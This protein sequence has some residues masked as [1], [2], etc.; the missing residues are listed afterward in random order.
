MQVIRTSLLK[1]DDFTQQWENALIALFFRAI[2][3]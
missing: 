1:T 3:S 2:L